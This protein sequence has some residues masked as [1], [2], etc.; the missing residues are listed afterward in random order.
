MDQ[1]TDPAVPILRRML[2]DAKALCDIDDDPVLDGRTGFL[3]AYLHDILR[4]KDPFGSIEHLVD[5][6]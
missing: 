5:Y 2:D 6:E 1:P 4:L 3:V